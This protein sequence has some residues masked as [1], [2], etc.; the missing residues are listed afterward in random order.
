[1]RWW[2]WLLGLLIAVALMGVGFSVAGAVGE[3]NVKYVPYV[4]SD[5]EPAPDGE[6]LDV[7][8]IEVVTTWA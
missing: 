8:P 7:A 1:M 2:V 3:M 4:V 5:D 6:L